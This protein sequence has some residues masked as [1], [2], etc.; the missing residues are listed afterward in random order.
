M[1]YNVIIQ[2]KEEMMDLEINEYR[3]ADQPVLCIR[4][5]CKVE[6]LPTLI[7]ASYGRIMEV[8]S[9]TGQQLAGEPYVAYFNLDMKALE[10]EMGFPVA[11]NGAG[12]GDVVAGFIPGGMKVSALYTGPYQQMAPAYDQL[13][14]YA[15]EHGY[16][17]T[18]VAYEHYLNGPET[19]PEQLQTR[20][21]FPLK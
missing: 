12:D 6:D 9:R 16:E 11:Q 10:V 5:T 15:Q 20:I 2:V 19:P 8:L 7:G 13:T 18:G 14:R 21:V 3:S 1:F 17:P 4:T